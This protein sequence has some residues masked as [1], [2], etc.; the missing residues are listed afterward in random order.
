MFMVLLVAVLVVGSWF[1]LPESWA[2]L[3][4][5]LGRR[6]AGLRSGYVKADG[7]HW[8]YLEGGSGPVLLL[9]HGFGGDADNWLKVCPNLVRQFRIIAPDLPGF[10][11]SE[12]PSDNDFDVHTQLQRLQS[13]LNRLQVTPEYVG[14]NSMGG[15][16]ATAYASQHQETL[17]G[18]WLLAPLGVRS[19]KN[20][21]MLTAIAANKESP[22]QISD[23]RQFTE[24]VLEPMFGRLPWIPYPLR[25]FYGKQAIRRSETAT[26][27]FKALLR[28]REALEDLAPSIRVPVLLQW[29]SK[30]VAVDVSGA[31]V[32]KNLFQN[33]VVHVEQDVGHLPMLE[34]PHQSADHFTGFFKQPGVKTS[35]GSNSPVSSNRP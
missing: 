6:N 3:L 1:A 31:E 8:H 22:L 24:R 12:R 10:G 34:V 2:R 17:S 19:A 20:S 29:G 14:G 11:A 15:W 23:Q 28:S 33:I 25:V 7:L 35:P 5:A 32:L 18:L 30:D 27:D 4:I 16:L 13:F 26:E 21:R 9:L